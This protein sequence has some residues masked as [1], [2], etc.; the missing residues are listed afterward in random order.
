MVYGGLTF[1]AQFALR[2]SSLRVVGRSGSP[3]PG[4]D[5]VLGRR[6]TTP[7]RSGPSRGRKL[8]AASGRGPPVGAATSGCVASRSAPSP[9]CTPHPGFSDLRA[10]RRY[11]HA[12]APRFS[13]N[14]A[15]GVAA[16]PLLQF[17]VSGCRDRVSGSEIFV[18]STVWGLDPHTA[19][20]LVFWSSGARSYFLLSYLF[21]SVDT[22]PCSAQGTADVGI[23]F[24]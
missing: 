21:G 3:G 23:V 7:A 12:A 2:L 16:S 22:A 8:P 10:P 1:G 17:G 4:C 6:W 20:I 24:D 15:V 14:V 19:A 18:I 9:R 5:P 11:V 13:L